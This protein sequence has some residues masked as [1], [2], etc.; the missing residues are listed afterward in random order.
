MA[1]RSLSRNKNTIRFGSRVADQALQELPQALND[2]SGRGFL[3]TVMDFRPTKRAF[4]EWILPL[5]FEL[6]DRR[7]RGMTFRLLLPDDAGL[8]QLFLNANWAHFIDPSH[9][10][11]TKD[12]PQHVAARRYSTHAEQQAAV[13]DVLDVVIRTVELRRDVIAALE[14]T[15]NEI[16]DNV[17]NHSQSETGGLVQLDT[18]RDGHRIKFVVADGG[19]G[20]PAA[21][22]EAYPG[23]DDREALAQS[24]KPGVTS[25]PESGQGNGLAGSLRIATYAEGSFRVCSGRSQLSVFADERTAQ[26]KTQSRLTRGHHYPGTIV[27]MELSTVADFSIG[28]ALALDGKVLP[29]TDLVDLRYGSGS[30]DLVIVVAEE[31]FG[32]GTRHAGVELRRKSLN[33]LNAE[34]TKRLILDWSG[35]TMVSSSFADEAVGKLFVDLGPTTFSARVSHSGAEP[36]VRSLLDRAVMQRVVQS[37]TASAGGSDVAGKAS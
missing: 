29:L 2:V 20:I 11:S 18:F 7:S 9:P 16:T 31:S 21:M 22:R 25:I 6:D 32:V 10:R 26:Y 8:R 33:L 34:P 12:H 35:L 28:E 13:S 36:L 19:R 4:A 37:M 17:L 15:I 24:V 14:W 27:M 5:I 23:L 30:G 1:F 3:E